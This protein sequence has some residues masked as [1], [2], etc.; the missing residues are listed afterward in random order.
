ML[1][2]ILYIQVYKQKTKKINKTL[3]NYVSDIVNFTYTS[4]KNSINVSW[5]NCNTSYNINLYKTINDGPEIPHFR[6]L[7]E[8]SYYF[9]K[10]EE[11]TAYNISIEPTN[12]L[13]FETTVRTL[14][15]RPQNLTSSIKNHT[16]TFNWDEAFSNECKKYKIMA[17]GKLQTDSENNNFT[18]TYNVDGCT[19][20]QVALI[21]DDNHVGQYLLMTVPGVVIN[22]TVEVDVNSMLLTWMPPEESSCIVGYTIIE[23]TNEHNTTATKY[24]LVNLEACT[25]YTVQVRAYSD[26]AYGDIV[27][28]TDTTTNPTNIDAVRNMRLDVLEDVLRATWDPPNLQSACITSYGIIMWNQHHSTI[29]SETINTTY[30]FTPLVACM[31]YNIM[32]K[33]KIGSREGVSTTLNTEIA[34]IENTPPIV[35]LTVPSATSLTINL[36]FQDYS[37]NMCDIFLIIVNCTVEGNESEE[38]R[39]VEVPY[40]DTQTRTAIVVIENLR[41]LTSYR[42]YAYVENTAGISNASDV[43]I[44]ETVEGLPSAPQNLTAIELDDTLL[45]TWDPPESIPGNFKKYR[46][47]LI[48][49]N[50]DDVPFDCYISLENIT[51]ETTELEYRYYN[52]MPYYN[53]TITVAAETGAGFGPEASAIVETVPKAPEE[54]RNVT[55]EYDKEVPITLSVHWLKPCNTNG[56]LKY[57]EYELTGQQIDDDKWDNRVNN[58]LAN[59]NGSFS[60]E[61]FIESLK[62]YFNYTLKLAAYVEGL[63]GDDIRGDEVIVTNII[64]PE[65]V[66]SAPQNLRAIVEDDSIL[67]ITWEPPES[68]AGRLGDYRIT[69]TPTNLDDVSSDCY[70]PLESIQD[71]TDTTQYQYH[72]ITPYY[73]Y[74]ITVAASTGAGFGP[75]A[76]TVIQTNPKA[77]EAPR[78][79][80]VE[81]N[82][83]T[84]MVATW[85]KPCNINGKLK[86]FAYELIGQHLEDGTWESVIDKVPANTDGSFDYELVV[87]SLKA[88]FNY[89]FKLVAYVEGLNDSGDIRGE[90]VTVVFTT[91]ELI[92]SDCDLPLETIEYETE[93]MEYEYLN[94]MPYYKYTIAV[95]ASTGAGYGPE[96]SLELQTEPKA[97]EAPRNVT[98]EYEVEDT[99][100]TLLV[101]WSKPCNINGKLKYFECALIGQHRKD[102]TWYDSDYYIIPNADGNFNYEH[103]IDSIKAYFNYTVKLVAYVEGS[104]DSDEI[105]GNE[106]VITNITTPEL[107]DCDYVIY[108]LNVPMPNHLQLLFTAPTVPMN[109]TA[110]D[111]T[112][113]SFNLYWDEPQSKNGILLS[114]RIVVE[115]A[116]SIH[117][118]PEDCP[119]FKETVY[120][121]TTNSSTLSLDFDEGLP[122]FHYLISVAAATNAGYGRESWIEV[123]T[124]SDEPEIPRDVKLVINNTLGSVYEAVL[125]I[126][127]LLPCNTNGDLAYFY[128]KL[129]GH[130]IENETDTVNHEGRIHPSAEDSD[131]F[132][133]ILENLQPVFHYN[134]SI[135]TC[136]TDEIC[137]ESYST[138]FT[139][140]D[141][142]ASPPTNMKVHNMTPHS[143]ILNWDEPAYKNGRIQSYILY[144]LPEKPMYYVPEGCPLPNVSEYKTVLNNT[145][146]NFEFEG[147][148][149]YKYQAAVVATTRT[150]V[151]YEAHISFI[152]P[153]GPSQMVREVSHSFDNKEGRNYNVSV[154]FDWL[155][156]CN[157]NGHLKR[158]DWDLVGTSIVDS[159][160]YNV[161]ESVYGDNVTNLGY[162]LTIS[163]LLPLYSYRFVIATIVGDGDEEVR[164]EEYSATFESP[165]G[166]PTEPTNLHVID[167]EA[168]MATIVWDRPEHENGEIVLYKFIVTSDGPAYNIPVGCS[169]EYNTLLYNVT[170]DPQMRN[171][172]IQGRSNFYYK[173]VLLAKTRT[174]EGPQSELQFKTLATVPEPVGNV[175]TVITDMKTEN[176][177]SDVE[178]SFDEPC[179][180]NDNFDHYAIEILGKRN[181]HV[182][183]NHKFKLGYDTQSFLLTLKPQYTYSGHIDVVT[184]FHMSSADIDSFVAPSGVP[185]FSVKTLETPTLTSTT[186]TLVLN[187]QLFEN[188]QGDILYYAIIISVRV[189]ISEGLGGKFDF[190][191][192]SEWPDSGFWSPHNTEEY[193]TTPAFW[194]PFQDTRS[195]NYTFVIGNGNCSTDNSSYCNGPLKPETRYAIRIRGYTSNA[196]R[197][198]SVIYFTTLP[199]ETYLALILGLI[200]G[201]LAAIML[202]TFIFFLWCRKKK[203]KTDTPTEETVIQVGK[204]PPISKHRFVEHCLMFEENRSQL[205]AEYS[206]LDRLSATEKPSSNV[207][208]A[209]NNKRK[210]RYINIMPYDETRVRL[211]IDSNDNYED[212]I[213]ASYIKG[214]SGNHEYIATQGPMESTVED[215]WRMIIQ[216][217]VGIIVMVAQFVEQS[218][219]PTFLNIMLKY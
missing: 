125:T 57:F 96:N 39:N 23:G 169:N 99:V 108:V 116:G 145:V 43:I 136:I 132:Q 194:A 100:I 83:A 62:P 124:S 69:I 84:S 154:K 37:A 206:H 141:G 101:N 109:L 172:A 106:S 29:D 126:T 129:N 214:Y 24:E 134:F 198:T 51:Y 191:N 41:Y 26:T 163:Q 196:Y 165:D 197:D 59:T 201:L 31:Q 55:I 14:P 157:T 127:W 170:V 115:T 199:E 148:P 103:V 155:L 45:V 3:K 82:S 110:I 38:Q 176:Y 11:C 171:Y 203:E 152:L 85:L 149:K 200:F 27:E 89:T 216:E 72:N 138:H 179:E 168:Y 1:L 187:N 118:I 4:Y 48:P 53:Y 74:T 25:K 121:Y 177:S 49:T 213:N 28:I 113:T 54:P 123:D 137:G 114:Y 120:N 150:G 162:S 146:F 188:S 207:A 76:S 66:P 42:C 97:P 22:L 143:G 211:T 133:L 142:Y 30:E 58:V 20:F 73:N 104:S 195:A 182:D 131:T 56:K 86:Y 35:T 174:G 215:F 158:F 91:P 12:G 78:N 98:V 167:L 47:S 130:S 208:M 5:D 119:H 17:N 94:S 217:D 68:I 128:W 193:Q 212:Y 93:K 173:V 164:G 71:E 210:N 186:A 117:H 192:E 189:D 181:G 32:V 79:V 111:I 107:L 219:V 88:Y 175:Q 50:E 10:L 70:T 6:W 166:Y 156:P 185:P 63:D 218:K 102:A 15:E 64:T 178:I 144:I 7:N 122:H 46:I 112:S 44:F 151:G 33:P 159:T 90:E 160:T 8:N 180:L 60:Y 204:P 34:P 87:D 161:T 9:Q 36:K 19:T 147:K 77:P 52:P 205:K 153:S 139:T 183:D 184:T 13:I 65:T 75:D 202:L 67:L 18:S 40:V 105:R 95:A 61:L 140:P 16:I 80:H 92:S 135:S 209:D 2:L 190:W 81:V 21:D